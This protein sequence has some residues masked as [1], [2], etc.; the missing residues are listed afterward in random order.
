MATAL[1]WPVEPEVKRRLLLIGK[2]IKRD[3][4]A[5]ACRIEEQQITRIFAPFVVLESLTQA[6][7]A[8]ESSPRW[9]LEFVTAGEQL[10][11]TPSMVQLFTRLNKSVLVNQYGPTETHVVIQN[12]QLRICNWAADRGE[13]HPF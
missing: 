10:H 3:L 1:G 13:Q 5:L 12:K 4:P 9:L 11:V 7:L 6:L 2:E 8:L